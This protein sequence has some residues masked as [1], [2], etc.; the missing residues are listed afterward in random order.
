MSTFQSLKSSHNSLSDKVHYNH[1]TGKFT[2]TYL[3]C[4]YC[5]VEVNEMGIVIKPTEQIRKGV[6]IGDHNEC[7]KRNHSIHKI[8][9]LIP[10]DWSMCIYHQF[11]LYCLDRFL[12]EL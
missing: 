8:H 12:Y 5:D 10:L 7:N 1:D 6:M 11:I 4:H 2:Q 3:K 9:A